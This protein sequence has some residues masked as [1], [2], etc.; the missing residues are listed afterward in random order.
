M[1]NWVYFLFDES[2]KSFYR[3][4]RKG[5]LSSL[6]GLQESPSRL[7]HLIYPPF[8][9]YKI[10]SWIKESKSRWIVCKIIITAAKN[11]RCMFT[12]NIWGTMFPASFLV[13][14]LHHLDTWLL[15]RRSGRMELDFGVRW[16]G[17]EGEGG[18][19]LC[20]WFNLYMSVCLYVP[21]CY[22]FSLSIFVCVPVCVSVCDDEL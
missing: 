20:V 9:A 13:L 3:I 18:A 8:W 4:Q 1:V 11:A 12:S 21:V 15:E 5:T 19:N 16:W 17:L 2:C 14:L 6:F 22:F 10:S 7:A